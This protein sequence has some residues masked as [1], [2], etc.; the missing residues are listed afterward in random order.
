MQQLYQIRTKVW[1][2][3]LLVVALALAACAPVQAPASESANTTT[4]ASTS[5]ANELVIY[6]SR[7]ESLFNPVVEAF[8]QAHSEIKVTVL[9]GKGGELGARLLEEKANPQADLFIN[10]DVMAIVDLAN[11][12]LFAPNDSATIAALPATQRAADGSW[13]ALTLRLRVIMYNKDL[14]PEADLPQSVFDLTDPKW[15]GQVGAT[16]STSDAMIAHVAALI[17]LVGEEKATAFVKGLVDNGTQFFGG[18]TDIRKAVGNGELKLGF[19]NHYYYHLSRT[20]GAP[21]G[22]VYPDQADLGMLVN[23][24]NAGI[25]QG[26]KHADAAKL[27]IDFLLSPE[28][29]KI[30][31]EKNFE[32]PLL[33][34]V[35]LA[36]GV[37]PL[38]D[39]KLAEINLTELYE[40]RQ[41]A[42]ELAQG[43][44]LP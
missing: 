26:A 34:D 35:A 33:A 3:G 21:V 7:A 11:Q 40:L 32:Y 13:T 17:K 36:E 10:S 28:G 27:F 19:V 18:H 9:T 43:V 16:D 39:L 44:G 41:Q 24:T 2:V 31:A 30:F 4:A 15:Q 8:N 14:V 38:A 12:G 5:G 20:E 23:S 22:I 25:I 37:D 1:L 6:T 29:Q 42:K